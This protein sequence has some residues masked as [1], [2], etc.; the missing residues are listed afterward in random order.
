MRRTLAQADALLLLSL[1]FRDAL[2]G[3]PR[4]SPRIGAFSSL[5]YTPNLQHL[6][7]RDHGAA[8]TVI[9]P[10]YQFLDKW[11]QEQFMEYLGAMSLRALALEYLPLYETQVIECLQRVPQL[12]EL[13]LEVFARR[14]RSETSATSCSAR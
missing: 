2:D 5:L 4:R 14:G 1:E 12:T 6:T 13:V 11:P 3:S 7:L 9:G 10:S 8:N